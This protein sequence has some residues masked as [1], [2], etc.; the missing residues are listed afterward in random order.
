MIDDYPY[1]GVDFREDIDLALPEDEYWENSG[2]TFMDI[3][4]F[5][6]LNI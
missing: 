1:A 6:F 4:I 2:M 3:Y 5:Y